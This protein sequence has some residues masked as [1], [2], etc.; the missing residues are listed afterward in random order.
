L[1]KGESRLVEHE[2]AKVQQCEGLSVTIPVS[3]PSPFVEEFDPVSYRMNAED[4]L[5]AGPFE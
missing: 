3:S 5:N 4:I 2:A 1:P